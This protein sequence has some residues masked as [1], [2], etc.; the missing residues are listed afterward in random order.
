MI[1]PFLQT[2]PNIVAG[3]RLVGLFR[4]TEICNFEKKTHEFL[5]SAPICF[6]LAS[7]WTSH[8]R[9]PLSNLSL[10]TEK[11]HTYMWKVNKPSGLNL[12]H[13]L[14]RI[15]ACCYATR[16]AFTDSSDVSASAVENRTV[17]HPSVA[18][19]SFAE[20]AARLG[21]CKS[22]KREV[23]GWYMT[24]WVRCSSA[25]GHSWTGL[26]QPDVRVKLRFRALII[27]LWYN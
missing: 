19:V 2:N 8:S 10:L 7:S 24:T 18:D 1:W 21:E 20:P 6:N 13:P 27:P 26:S 14:S 17:D 16:A 25:S 12:L 5:L 11:P 3:N 9:K 4:I 23:V 22:S 15:P